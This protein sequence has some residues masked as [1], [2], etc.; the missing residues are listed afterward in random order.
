MVYRNECIYSNCS[1][2]TFIFFITCV[3]LYL[4]IT[5]I[6]DI[7]NVCFTT[8]INVNDLPLVAWFAKLTVEFVTQPINGFCGVPLDSRILSIYLEQLQSSAVV[9]A[10]A[11]DS[12]MTA[13][14]TERIINISPRR[15]QQT[16]YVC[17]H[18]SYC[19]VKPLKPF[20]S[21]DFQHNTK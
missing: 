7:V 9:S 8:P 10:R 18:K 13:W 16:E 3:I 17:P 5:Y 4:L 1:F 14:F 6:T 19:K 15:L 11:S 20:I 2:F 21:T 12:G